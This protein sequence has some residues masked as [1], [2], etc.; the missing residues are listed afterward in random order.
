MWGTLTTLG[1]THTLLKLFVL[2]LRKLGNLKNMTTEMLV[3]APGPL[4]GL[5]GKAHAGKD[6]ACKMLEEALP[7]RIAR[8]AF[9]DALKREVAKAFGCSVTYI[10]ANKALFRP[11]LQAWGVLR[12]EVEG[13]WYWVDQ[14]G[15]TVEHHRSRGRVVVVTD[16]RFENEVAWVRANGGLIVRVERPGHDNGVPAHVSETE[17]EGVVA[18]YTLTA[19]NLTQLR[20][21]VDR[22]REALNL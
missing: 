20:P 16:T 15:V 1:L 14:V 12:R 17:Q 22:L 18:D 6:A 7:G 2:V 10:E 3:N 9:A 13:S 21:E 4:I 11:I 19:S 5:V 8:A